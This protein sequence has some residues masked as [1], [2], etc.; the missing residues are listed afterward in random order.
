MAIKAFTKIAVGNLKNHPVSMVI[1]SSTFFCPVCQEEHDL[2]YDVNDDNY[3]SDCDFDL[4]NYTHNEDLLE[5]C[6]VEDH[7]EEKLEELR[8]E[9]EN[10]HEDEVTR[11]QAIIKNLEE[12]RDNLDWELNQ[13]RE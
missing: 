3:T 4:D 13:L 1:S 12:E 10:E 5:C 7:V 11:L 8:E 9:L 2:E 6:T